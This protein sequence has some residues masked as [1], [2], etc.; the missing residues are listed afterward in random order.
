MNGRAGSIKS[1]GSKRPPRSLD[2]LVWWSLAAWFLVSAWLTWGETLS[3]A[4]TVQERTVLDRALRHHREGMKSLNAGRPDDARRHFDEMWR[5]VQTQYQ[6]QQ[7]HAFEL[8]YRSDLGMVHLIRGEYEEAWKQFDRVVTGRRKRVAA[9]LENRYR[10]ALALNDR[11]YAAKLMGRYGPAVNDIEEARKL[12]AKF[13]DRDLIARIALNAIDLYRLVG[14]FD[15]AIRS[16]PDA[17]RAKDTVLIAKANGNLGLVHVARADFAKAEP[18]LIESLRLWRRIDPN[19]A[20]VAKAHSNLGW[21][22]QSMGRL[23]TARKHYET[24]LA[25]FDRQ[26]R[27]NRPEKAF[28]LSNLGWLNHVTG[29]YQEAEQLYR[30]G[31]RIR[32]RTLPKF[33]PRIALS[34]ANLAMVHAAQNDWREAVRL[35]DGSRRLMRHYVT[36]ELPEMHEAIQLKFLLNELD[37]ESHAFNLHA[38]LSFALLQPNNQE[39]IDRTA[40]WV[41]NG[42]GVVHQV[43]AQQTLKKKQAGQAFQ[44]QPEVSLQQVRSRIPPPA[45][46]IEIA[47]IRVWNPRPRGTN[48]WQ[49]DRHYVAWIIPAAGAGNVKVIDL[50]PARRVHKAI[51]GMAAFFGDGQKAVEEIRQ[52]IRQSHQRV[53]TALQRVAELV[54][55]PL[56][57]ELTEIQRL[58]VSPDSDL[59]QVPWAAL[60]LPSGDFAINRFVISYV[61]SGRDLA[62]EPSSSA[63]NPPEILAAPNYDLDLNTVTRR[64]RQLLQQ[65]Q[66]NE[67]VPQP[68]GDVLRSG[69]LAEFHFA[70]LRY[71][72]R[73]ANDVRAHVEAYAKRQARMFVGNDATEGVFR[74]TR[75]PRVI[76]LSTHGYFLTDT[77]AE[78][79]RI[80]LPENP[81]KRCGLILA[82]ANSRTQADSNVIEDGILT[83]QEIVAADLHGTELVVL[84]ACE[85]GVGIRSDGEGVAGLR[86]AFQLAGARSVLATLWEVPDRQ[87]ALLV[88]AFFKHLGA[89]HSKAEALALAQREFI[90]NPGLTLEGV[91]HP[92]FWAGLTLTGE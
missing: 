38:A 30:Q 74:T 71:S 61:V 55:H 70:P 8:V 48:P 44:P 10:L 68:Q 60:K 21:L 16:G 4:A 82:G 52:D 63:A 57:P 18:M 14:D 75:G 32:R 83:G 87:T 27:P 11:G 62:V 46:L 84:S 54:L 56:M 35:M 58:I 22:Y 17:L 89:G 23:D 7:L 25:I 65:F 72:L 78:Q 73:E 36:H 80:R 33:H 91:P 49:P 85:T 1:G 42:K 39:V 92:F 79:F 40:E 47:K 37:D 12:A 43:L 28:C 88:I 90:A 9:G 77:R 24:A 50:G 3:T 6:G 76:M 34:L 86:Q 20:E 66:R 15:A 59:W 81:L 41:L 67:P 69:E 51:Q 19:H 64:T 29:D 26:D 2:L 53:T 45:V 13:E 31:Y 5:L